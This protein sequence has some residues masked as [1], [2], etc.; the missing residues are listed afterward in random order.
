M[1]SE[2]A[3]PYCRLSAYWSR[4]TG[5][6]SPG[7]CALNID[8]PWSFMA[9]PVAKQPTPPEP[10]WSQLTAINHEKAFSVLT[11]LS[12]GDLLTILAKLLLR[13]KPGDLEAAFSDYAR[14]A[15]LGDVD[16]QP[17]QPLLDVT[18]E[19]TEAAMRGAYYEDFAVNW[20]NSTQTSGGTQEF[21][22]RLD[23]LFDR[24]IDESTTGDAFEVCASY[25]LIFDL[26]REIDKFEKDI[27]FWADEGGVWNFGIPWRR[28]L[29]PY[30]RCLMKT[31]PTECRAKAKA[32][33]DTLVDR[34]DQDGVRSLLAEVLAGDRA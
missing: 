22:A 18:R 9:P 21:E 29:P 5:R 15:E 32:V 13:L 27:V 2:P 31:A 4:R 26:L 11:R 19:F 6:S 24:F 17:R 3:A 16:P 34:V 23:L 20:R 10:T 33:I 14:P 28:V 7:T 25:E 1:Q 30:F 8:A 12:R